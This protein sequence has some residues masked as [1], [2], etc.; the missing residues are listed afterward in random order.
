MLTSKFQVFQ[1][2]LAK[3]FGQSLQRCSRLG[4]IT[5]RIGKELTGEILKFEDNQLHLTSVS[6]ESI[7]MLLQLNQELLQKV[8]LFN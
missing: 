6:K 1:T 2:T 7:T 3:K 5:L 4:D 8:V